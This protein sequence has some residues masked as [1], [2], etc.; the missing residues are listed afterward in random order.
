GLGW[1]L[2]QT[3]GADSGLG[4]YGRTWANNELIFLVL[5]RLAG[6]PLRARW[7]VGA[8]LALVAAA[9]VWRR[10]EPS[11]ATRVSLRAGFLLSPVAP[12]W[13]LGWALLLEPLAPSAPWLLLSLTAVLSYGALAPPPAGSAFHLSVLGRAIEYGLP[14]ALALGLAVRGR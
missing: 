5:E 12:P 14:L 13:S 9:L 10:V 7:T 4:A 11:K 1:F 6:D 3:R 2:V 8:L